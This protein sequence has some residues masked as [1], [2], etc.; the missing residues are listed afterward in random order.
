MELRPLSPALGVEVIGVDVGRR[1]AA[2]VRD[3]VVAAWREHH[4]VLLRDQ[5]L[6]ATQHGAYAQWFGTIRPPDRLV[7]PDL[8]AEAKHS[9]LSNT[10]ADGTGGTAD[11]MRH[12][13]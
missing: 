4:L 13:D 7:H 5:D 6:S 1:Q 9:H 8:T 2:D 11:V 12:Q 10:R 3:R